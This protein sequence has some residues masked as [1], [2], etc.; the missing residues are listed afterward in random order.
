M[1]PCISIS[2]NAVYNH[3][4][5]AYRITKLLKYIYNFYQHVELFIAEKEDTSL[6][7]KFIIPH[8]LELSS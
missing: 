1:K 3:P 8:Y 4:V 7:V 2:E 5:A 6:E